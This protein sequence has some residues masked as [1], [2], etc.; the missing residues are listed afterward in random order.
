MIRQTSG[1]IVASSAPGG[2]EKA[3]IVA[4]TARGSGMDR[5]VARPAPGVHSRGAVRTKRWRTAARELRK[6]R[7][8][9][10]TAERRFRRLPATGLKRKHVNALVADYRV[11]WV[12]D[13]KAVKPG[14]LSAA[15]GTVTM[16]AELG[17]R[18]PWK[19]NVRSSMSGKGDVACSRPA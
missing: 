7:A 5:I 8:E 6:L 19:L 3:L 12:Q 13:D 18:N 4:L 16:K 15:S 14:H 11:R 10:E 2:E 9:T 17:A 1:A